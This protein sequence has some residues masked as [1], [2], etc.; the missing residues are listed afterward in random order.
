LVPSGIVYAFADP[1]LES[2]SAAQKNFLR[3][4]PENVQTI[5]TKLREIA[6]YRGIPPETLPRPSVLRPRE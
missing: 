4:G 1:R 5:Q 6:E 2:M 3:M